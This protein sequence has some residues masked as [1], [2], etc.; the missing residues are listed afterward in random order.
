[1]LRRVA[2]RITLENGKIAITFRKPFQRAAELAVS[3]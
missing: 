1:M 3:V 2:E